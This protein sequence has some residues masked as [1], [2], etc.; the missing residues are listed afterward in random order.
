[1]RGSTR[2]LTLV[3][4]L[5]SHAHFGSLGHQEMSVA[6]DPQDAL[7]SRG[8]SWAH[9]SPSKRLGVCLAN[10][11]PEPSHN[12]QL[13]D[14]SSL[15]SRGK[16]DRKGSN[17]PAPP[18]DAPPAS[19]WLPH[20]NNQCTRTGVR[21]HMRTARRL[22]ASLDHRRPSKRTLRGWVHRVDVCQSEALHHTIQLHHASFKIASREVEL[23]AQLCI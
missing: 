7:F 8:G 15:R 13:R 16:A 12:P 10:A 5:P 9:A 4:T 14:H 6:S 19:Q 3:G 20:K 17:H 22:G 11:H 18:R 1:M 23:Y 21:C 2:A